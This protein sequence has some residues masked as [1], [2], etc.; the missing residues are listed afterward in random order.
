MQTLIA[1][2][3]TSTGRHY[4]QAGLHRDT[5]GTTSSGLIQ[6]V[7]EMGTEQMFATSSARSAGK[8][9]ISATT[10]SDPSRA[11]IVA[12]QHILESRIDD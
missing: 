5:I 6:H 4:E 10:S 7:Q 11:Q 2:E 9:R 8:R 12:L 1:F 3:M